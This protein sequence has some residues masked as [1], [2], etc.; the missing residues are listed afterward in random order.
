MSTYNISKH[1]NTCE[2]RCSAVMRAA[3]SAAT[4]CL[5]AANSA[6]IID[7]FQSATPPIDTAGHFTF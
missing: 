5:N 1:S 7:Q 4:R 2:T 3:D 6:Y